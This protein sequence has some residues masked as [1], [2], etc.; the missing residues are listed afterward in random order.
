MIPDIIK[1]PWLNTKSTFRQLDDYACLHNKS[2]MGF[3]FSVVNHVEIQSGRQVV[4]ESREW[5]K[6]CAQIAKFP[7][8]ISYFF[9]I[10]KLFLKNSPSSLC[11]WCGSDGVSGRGDVPLVMVCLLDL[12]VNAYVARSE[13]WPVVKDHI[14]RGTANCC[15]TVKLA[16]VRPIRRMKNKHL[17]TY[18]LVDCFLK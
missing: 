16:A 13:C 11:V 2:G 10:I 12:G 7:R 15:I 17:S 3:N 18:I 6:K 9:G 1:K 5:I 14:L 8:E 4:L